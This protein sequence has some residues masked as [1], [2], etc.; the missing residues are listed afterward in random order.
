MADPDPLIQALKWQAAGCAAL[1]SA[2]SAGLLE[3]TQADVA[4][5]GPTRALFAPWA[6]ASA[7]TPLTAAASLRFLGAL[8]DLVLG[9]RYADESAWG[10]L[11]YPGPP[12][13][14]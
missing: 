9:T 1:G 13:V 11:G 12:N 10:L 4:A 7:R 8:H 3:R 14:E 5:G 6:D 2:F